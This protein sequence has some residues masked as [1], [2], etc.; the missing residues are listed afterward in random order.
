MPPTKET[1]GKKYETKPWATMLTASPRECMLMLTSKPRKGKI[2]SPICTRSN[3][4]RRSWLVAVSLNRRRQQINKAEPEG[5]PSCYQCPIEGQALLL[6][7]PIEGHDLL[8][9]SPQSKEANRSIFEGHSS[10]Q[11]KELF[12]SSFYLI[13]AFIFLC[14]SIWL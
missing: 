1:G 10:P 5:T 3:Q 9:V 12:F 11:S 2:R 8:H 4:N 14:T 13:F 7:W 6:P